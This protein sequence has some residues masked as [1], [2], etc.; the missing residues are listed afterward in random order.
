MNLN[1]TKTYLGTMT[2]AFICLFTITASAQFT[3]RAAF[4]ANP[5][6]IQQAVDQFRADLGPLN[7]NVRGSF[8]TGRR[9]I[10][11]DGVPE[12]S[13]AP[14]FLLP[15]FFNF[16]SPRGVMFTSTA[17]P[18][19]LGTIA[20]P[21]QVSSSAA[22]GVPVEF[23]NINPTYTTEFQTFSAQKLFASSP[24]SNVLEITFFIPGTNIP[25]TVTGFGAVFCDADTPVTHMQFY[26]QNGRILLQPNGQIVGIDKGLS[27]QGVSYSDGTR[28]AR[29][30]IVL[31]NAPLSAANTDGVNGVDVVA[32]DDF[33]YS[34]PRAME[35]H[36]GDF[37]GDGTPDLAV[38]RPSAGQ[39]FILGSGTNTFSVTQF[40]LDGDVPVDADF[41]G[42]KRSDIAVYRP[43]TGTWFSLNSSNG[44][45][46]AVQFGLAEDRPV[47]GDYDKDGRSDIAVWRPSIGDYFIL[48]SSNGLARETH[49]GTNGD[50]PVN[51]AQ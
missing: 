11:W 9:E 2:I 19:I 32:L 28:I 36:P 26:D 23:G 5:A 41:D 17:G 15:D 43:S 10:N 1:F 46:S 18:N 47:P 48:N 44:Q 24:D 33:I 22:S 6:A 3:E 50:I 8:T 31:G 12:G 13:S 51:A 21:F 25:A 37:D 30:V 40:G 34:E 7:P 39:W 20:Q 45:F 14:N 29:V 38:Y 49:W 35:H 27:F 4:G 16:N 42:D